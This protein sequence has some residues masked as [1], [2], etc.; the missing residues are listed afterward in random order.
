MMDP[1]YAIQVFLGGL[2][3]GGIYSLLALGMS[4]NLGLLGLMN[5]A[6]GSV[7]VFGGLVGY[8]LVE[9]GGVSPFLALVLVP[10]LFAG[11]GAVS[12]PL[13]VRP[14]SERRPES[15]FVA[16]LLIT[17]GL[18]FILEEVSATLLTHPLVGL[19]LGFSPW[20]WKGLVLSPLSLLLLSVLGGCLL[21]LGGFLFGTQRG[22]ALRA[23]PQD[24]VGAVLVGISLS[25]ARSLAWSLGL[26]AAA[27]AGM[28]WI[29]LYPI[30][31]FMG[32]K[33][34]V[35][36][37]LMVMVVGPGEILNAVGAGMIWGI[38]ESAGSAVLG[39]QWGLL[40]PLGLFLGWAAFSPQEKI[41]FGGSA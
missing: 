7:L 34:T 2:L 19:D 35:T 33:L 21:L 1:T 8:L 27:L 14:L 10:L 20:Q 16:F 15:A 4:L 29:F 18:A 6:H 39:A 13:L 12:Y 17:L 36:A 22:W 30:T 5:L 40:L 37:M 32:L 9:K 11:L 25:S 31:S 38:L 23:I 3:L 24:P 28:F 26:C 41:L